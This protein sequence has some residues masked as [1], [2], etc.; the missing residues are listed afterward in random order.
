VYNGWRS[1][2]SHLLT[3]E[4][5]QAVKDRLEARGLFM[6]HLINAVQGNDAALFDSVIK[7]ISQ[8]F[9]ETVVFAAYPQKLTKMQN[10]IIVAADFDLKPESVLASLPPGK[11]SLR[12]LLLT[13]VPPQKYSTRKGYLLTDLFNPVE[14]LVAQTLKQ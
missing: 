8:V 14:Y 4:F 11:K 10:I 5:F 3:R 6:I 1:V 7:T 9:P 2:P 12:E 13:R